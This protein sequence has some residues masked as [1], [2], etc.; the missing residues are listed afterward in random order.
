VQNPFLLE[1]VMLAEA[2]IQFDEV[3][4]L[5]PAFILTKEGVTGVLTYCENL[6]HDRD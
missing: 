6:D 4:E 3:F 5:P 1:M 2:E